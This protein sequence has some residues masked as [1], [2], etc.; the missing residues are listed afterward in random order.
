MLVQQ[1]NKE[2][3]ASRMYLAMDLWFRFNDYPGS[4]QW[5]QA[6]C[7][8]ERV[9]AMK[10]FDHLSLRTTEKQCAVTQSALTEWDM[11]KFSSQAQEKVSEV[12]LMALE[13]ERANSVEYSKIAKAAA[14]ENDFVTSQF[15][16]WFHNEQLLEENAVEDIYKKAVKLERTGGLYAAMDQDFAKMAH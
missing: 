11:D 8:E 2:L 3:D 12:W 13:N 9:H 15:L 7:Q 1:A 16:N 5:C 6:H 10:I 4:A 14:E